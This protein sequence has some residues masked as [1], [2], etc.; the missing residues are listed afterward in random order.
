MQTGKLRH[1]CRISPRTQSTSILD[2]YFF[3]SLSGFSVYLEGPAYK[4][5]FWFWVLVKLS[6]QYLRDRMGPGVAWKWSICMLIYCR[7]ATSSAFNARRVGMIAP[8]S[9][10]N[11]AF[12]ALSASSS[13]PAVQC[14]YTLL[15]WTI[16]L[17]VTTAPPVWTVGVLL[18]AGVLPVGVV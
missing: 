3:A 16:S 17:L 12:I 5:V 2:P 9:P 8:V 15:K 18:C 7:W 11:D 13:A 6:S 10:D 1:F 4:K 14:S